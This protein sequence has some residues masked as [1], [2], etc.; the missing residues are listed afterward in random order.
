MNHLI[1]LIQQYGLGLVFVNVL[2]VQAGLPVPAY[3]TLIVAGATRR[4]GGASLCA[5]GRRARRRGGDRRHRLVPRRAAASGCAC[6]GRCAASRCRRIRACAQT[7]SIFTRFGAA[8]MLFAKFVPGFASVATAMAGAVRLALLEIP[9]VRR[10]SA[11][12]LWVGVAI[13][14]GY[15]FRDAIADVLEMLAGAGQVGLVLVVAAFVAYDRVEVVAAPA[16]HPAAA[17]GPRDGGR[18]ARADGGR[19]QVGDDPRRA[20]AAVAG[21]ERPHPRRARGRHAAHRRGASMACR[22]DGEVIVYCACPNEASAVKVAKALKRA[23]LQARAAAA[24]RHRRVDRRGARRR[25]L[26][27]ARRSRV[28]D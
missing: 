4:D 17:D 5:A 14:L 8:S 19:T 18:A 15:M 22:R 23:R 9:A 16:V 27:S 1:M 13:A 26:T 12:L 2:V 11:P 24:R 10:A 21:G 7:E 25:A 6:C 3:P 28:L 20:L